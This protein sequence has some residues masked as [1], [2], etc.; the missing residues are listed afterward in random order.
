MLLKYY[1]GNDLQ[2]NSISTTFAHKSCYAS[3][4]HGVSGNPICYFVSD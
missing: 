2:L 4:L 1:I 3:L